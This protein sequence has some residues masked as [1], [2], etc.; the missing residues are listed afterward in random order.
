MNTLGDR[1][2]IAR[3][4]SGLKQTQVKERTNINNKT[5]SGYENNVSEPDM[6]TLATLTELYEVS[7]KW[8]LTG[9]GEMNIP[10]QIEKKVSNL[11]DKDERDIGKRMEKIKKDLLEGNSDDNSDALSFMGEPM[12]EEAIE[13]LL[14]ALEHAERLATLANKK[15]I[16]KKYR[17]D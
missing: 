17:K 5:L 14:E 12:S 11:T 7:Y 2:R 10:R 1:L 3:Q 15:F 4:K 16:P 8:L 6:N 9:E 13:S